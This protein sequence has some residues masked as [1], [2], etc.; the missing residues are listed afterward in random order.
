MLF[1]RLLFSLP[2]CLLGLTFVFNLAPWRHPLW[3]IAVSAQSI[4]RIISSTLVQFNWPHLL[5]LHVK[6]VVTFK[7]YLKEIS[8]PR[9][10]DVEETMCHVVS[11]LL[12]LR[13]APAPTT[14]KPWHSDRHSLLCKRNHDLVNAP[15]VFTLTPVC[16]F[17]LFV[18]FLF[19]FARVLPVFGQDTRDHTPSS[20]SDTVLLTQLSTTTTS[21]EIKQWTNQCSRNFSECDA[22]LPERSQE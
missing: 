6:V 9:L 17:A 4:S 8:Y 12:L 7:S 5:V 11:L 14:G 3:L 16:C 10:F 1:S 20:N 13:P 2:S 19:A 15:G 21:R 22:S 18:D